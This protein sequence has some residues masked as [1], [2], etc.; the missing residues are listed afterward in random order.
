MELHTEWVTTKRD[1]Q[2]MRAFYAKAEAASKAKLPAVLVIQEIWG[3]DQHIQDMAERFAMSGYLAIAPD[4]YSRG[5]GNPAMTPERIE[6][7]KRFLDTMPPAAW[8]DQALRDQYIDKEPEPKAGHI[9]ET[10]GMLFAPR[11]NEAYMADLK[12]W[13]DYIAEQN[14]T[15]VVSIGY[16]MGGQLSFLLA[17]SDSRLKAA[18][19]NYG[20]A[21]TADEMAK[22]Q[23]PVYGFYGGT[24]HRITDQVPGV[25]ETMKKLGRDFQYRIYPSAGH[26]FFN[27]S[28]AS[29]DPDAA[30]NAWAE[31]LM[32][33]EKH[34]K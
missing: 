9:R 16:C 22:I 28:R 10:L 23:S 27:D 3:P 31:T 29:Y 30:R 6:V 25:A 34:T 11:D 4:L 15:D 32:F 24:D 21:P 17:A 33:F 13:I 5:G 1:G 26:A 14:V 19:C 12:C 8:G 18:V 7:V 2:S 20:T